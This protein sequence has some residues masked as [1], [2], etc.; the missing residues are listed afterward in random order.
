MTSPTVHPSTYCPITCAVG[1]HPHVVGQYVDEP[2][3]VGIEEDEAVAPSAQVVVEFALGLHHVLERT[4]A[5]Q[6]CAS[7]VGD[8]SAGR[9]GRLGQCAYV[10]RMAGP[11]LD[12]G[13]VVLLGKP[14]QRLGHAHVVVEVALGV[15][16]VV[17]LAEHGGNEFLRGGLAVGARDAYDGNLELA[18]MLAG[19]VL[20]GLEAVGDIY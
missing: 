18:A 7:H 10:A 9:L 4:E 19:Q 13:D 14:E 11:R 20:E 12:D 1:S 6:V 16:H 17:S 5:L 8:E 3:V 2:F 15:E